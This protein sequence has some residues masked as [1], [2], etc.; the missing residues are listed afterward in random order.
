[1]CAFAW[2]R[3]AGLEEM[4][5]ITERIATATARS[6]RA[7]LASEPALHDRAGTF[8]FLVRHSPDLAN[9]FRATVSRNG[10][11]GYS[12]MPPGVVTHV[13]HIACAS[14]T[15]N[16]G[17]RYDRESGRVEVITAAFTTSLRT[18]TVQP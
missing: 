1:M 11:D 8:D 9:G 3:T 7:A 15:L 10:A 4:E 14:G 13:G 18:A 2:W 17:F 6:D 12:L 16:L 5:A